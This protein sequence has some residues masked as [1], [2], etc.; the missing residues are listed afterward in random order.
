MR[1]LVKIGGAQLESTAAQGDLVRSLASARA[2]GHELVLV[3]GGGK[4]IRALSQRLGI[5]ERM[6]AGLRVTDAETA[7]VV[8]MVLAGLVNRQLVHA[9]ESHG[10]RAV[11][12]SGADGSTFSARKALADGVDLGY[13]GTAVNVDPRLCRTLLDNGY[14][15]V[16]ATTAPLARGEAAPAD[17]FYNINADLAAG[18]LARALDVD[19][20][21]FLTDV[22]G[23]LDERRERIAELTHERA[24]D[25]RA[26]GVI[27][28]GMIPKVEAGLAALDE[29]PRARIKIALAE[30][31]NSVLEALEPWSGTRFTRGG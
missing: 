29:H 31:A 10:L 24:R 2:R 13:V 14:L 22:P 18:P 4:Q 27:H 16:V 15:P 9:L 25:L 8:L 21:M 12:L 6:H 7:D 23:V 1:I 26:R 3:H 28:G 17:H 30:G 20:L 19:A 11:G 5:T